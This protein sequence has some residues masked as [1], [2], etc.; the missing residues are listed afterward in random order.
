MMTGFSFVTPLPMDGDPRPQCRPPR[1]SRASRP[2]GGPLGAPGPSILPISPRGAARP[3]AKATTR[4]KG[5]SSMQTTPQLLQHRHVLRQTRRQCRPVGSSRP[6]AQ[7]SL[8]AL[9]LRAA[10]PVLPRARELG[11]ER[12]RLRARGRAQLRR[13]RQHRLRR[14]RNARSSRGCP[15]ARSSHSRH[16]PRSTC[17]ARARHHA[18]AV[19]A[20]VR[21]NHC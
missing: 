3:G 21:P 10:A 1:P 9:S 7:S 11:Q 19:A 12:P 15:A 20:F 16:L 4:S 5:L 18:Y 14:G 17:A 13:R 2:S 6:A 8:G